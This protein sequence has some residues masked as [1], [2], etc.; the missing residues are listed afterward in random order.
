M[1][2]LLK[3]HFFR[4]D[5]EDFDSRNHIPSFV[6]QWTYLDVGHTWYASRDVRFYVEQ[7]LAAQRHIKG[8]DIHWHTFSPESLSDCLEVAAHLCKRAIGDI[9]ITETEDEIFILATVYSKQKKMP[10]VLEIFCESTRRRLTEMSPK[11]WL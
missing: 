11:R 6:N 3:D 9:K 1:E 2:H 10:S 4:A 7:L 5:G 8:N